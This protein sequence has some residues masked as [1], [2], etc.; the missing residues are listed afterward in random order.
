VRILDIELRQN[1][2]WNIFRG[3]MGTVPEEFPYTRLMH[4]PLDLR[5]KE[6]IMASGFRI[7]LAPFFGQL[8]VTPAVVFGRQNSKEPREFGGNLDCKELTAGSMIYLPVWSSVL[9]R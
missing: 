2:G 4:V 3:Y 5:S 6:A 1:W 8:A 7:P 9:D